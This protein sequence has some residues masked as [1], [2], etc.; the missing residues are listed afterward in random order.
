MTLRKALNLILTAV[1]VISIAA[2]GALTTL[3]SYRDMAYGVLVTYKQLQKQPGFFSG[4]SARLAAFERAANTNLLFKRPL[5]KLNARMQA[6]IGKQMLSFGGSTMVTCSGGQLYDLM[7]DTAA[8]QTNRRQ[9]IGGL[10]QLHEQ[11]Q[12]KGIP[13]IYGYAHTTLYQDGML[14]DGLRDG[15][16]DSNNLVADEIVQQL[17]AAGIK[18]LDSRQLMRDSGR[19]LNEIVYRTD[20]HW[21][22]FSAFEM[23]KAVV[24]ALNEGTRVKADRAAADLDNF[25]VEILP[26]AHISDIGNRLGAELVPPD[27]FQLLTPKFDTNI[28]TEIMKDKALQ[29]IDGKFEDAVL[30]KDEL[31]K[32]NGVPYKNCYNYYGQHPDV[33]YYHNEQAPEGR[34]LFV[35]DSFG[36]PV[37]SF[38]SLAVRDVCAIDLR[39]NPNKTVLDYVESFQPD[40]VVFV[41]CQEVMREQN[42]VFV[43]K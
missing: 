34:V 11:L 14:P 4:V 12:E 33:V 8:T 29:P 39:K 25:S 24:D 19:P 17:Q 27:D 38:L 18:T 22:V 30:F 43:D 15:I 6:G 32:A 5:E 35:K 9:T 28:H 1:L 36:T 13:M 31:P 37:A 7:A 26:G 23:Y 10:A 41:Q 3:G 20:A 42:F 16:D 21:S 2:V 40:A